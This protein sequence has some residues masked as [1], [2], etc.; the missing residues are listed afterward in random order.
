MIKIV[1]SIVFL[2]PKKPTE[3]NSNCL[4]APATLLFFDE[5]RAWGKAALDHQEA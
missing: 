4:S 5:F 1:P 2:F 3:A